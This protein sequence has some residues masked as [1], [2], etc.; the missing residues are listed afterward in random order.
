MEVELQWFNMTPDQWQMHM[1]VVS[2]RVVSKSA[3]VNCPQLLIS[4]VAASTNLPQPCL[5]GIRLKA[6]KL[7][8][9]PGS[10]VAAPGH[11]ANTWMVASRSGQRPH[12][13]MP[14]N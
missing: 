1:K 2:T 7:L 12:L 10:I 8:Q 6:T 5:Q 4:D 3:N 14:C 11:P 9:A 13:V